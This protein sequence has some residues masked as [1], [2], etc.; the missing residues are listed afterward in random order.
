[1]CNKK[2]SLVFVVA[3]P[4]PLAPPLFCRL[5]NFAQSLKWLRRQGRKFKVGL[6]PVRPEEKAVEDGDSDR[7][8]DGDAHA[9]E[10]GEDEEEEE[11]DDE[12]VEEDD[13]DIEEDEE[14]DE[15]SDVAEI[16]TLLETPLPRPLEALVTVPATTSAAEDGSRLEVEEGHPEF[17]ILTTQETKEERERKEARL[18]LALEFARAVYALEPLDRFPDDIPGEVAVGD[19]MDEDDQNA[20]PAGVDGG[21]VAA[22]VTEMTESVEDVDLLPTYSALEREDVEAAL[23]DQAS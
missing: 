3:F 16:E 4:P 1:M 10:D 18:L 2:L 17:E 5:S 21:G 6:R 8:I 14:E 22:A 19:T 7:E 23:A 12:E 20:A 11:E 15:D 9:D 13:E